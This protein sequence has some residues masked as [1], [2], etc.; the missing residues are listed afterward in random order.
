MTQ[1]ARTRVYEND[2][3][4]PTQRHSEE[5]EGRNRPPAGG[6]L[7]SASGTPYRK[8]CNGL[9]TLETLLSATLIW[10]P[11]QAGYV[12][13]ALFDEL[14]QSQ[15]RALLAALLWSHHRHPCCRTAKPQRSWSCGLHL[16]HLLQ[17]VSPNSIRPRYCDGAPWRGVARGKPYRVPYFCGMSCSFL[18]LIISEVGGRIAGVVP[19]LC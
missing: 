8:N 4:V 15:L 2:V 7:P 17:T 13:Q 11:R 3:L 16:F 19:G 5:S 1:A 6:A 14:C 10:R 12:G 9:H 18:P